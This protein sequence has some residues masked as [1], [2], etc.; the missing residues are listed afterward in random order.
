MAQTGGSSLV[1]G[2]LSMLAVKIVA[3]ALG[4]TQVALLS[5][6]QQLRQSAV[7]GATLTG[8]TA[9]V[10]GTSALSGSGRREFLRTSIVLMAIAT[11]VVSGVMMAFPEW[12]GR[13]AGLPTNRSGMSTYLIMAVIPA[14]AF[15]F[16]AAMMNAAGAIGSLALVQLAA[17]ATMAMMAYPI[18]SRV[19]R[20]S[21]QLWVVMLAFSS[22]A[23]AL[24]ASWALYID[25]ERLHGWIRGSGRWWDGS[26]V[27]RF[28]AISGSMFVSGMFSSWIVLAVRGQVVRSEGLAVGGQFDAAWA[29][30]MNQAG[31]VLASLQSYY[32]PTLAR[33]QDPEERSAHIGK[34]LT[35]AA[36]G[37]A[38]MIAVLAALKPTVITGLYSGQFTG[39]ARYLR[40]TLAGDYLKITS[41]ILSIPFVASGNMKAF[42][43]ADLAAYGMFALTAFGLTRWFDAGESAAMAFLTM[44]AVH[45]VFCGLWL[46]VR[47]EFRP[48]KRMIAVWTGGLGLV[49]ASSAAFWEQR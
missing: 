2:F 39:A 35:V 25:R 40:W 22:L 37:G 1:S 5:S 15:V 45:T 32:L 34:V 36:T 47:G 27:G 23:A 19:A 7:T 10:Q 48:D 30:S 33:T 18:A 17:P 46:S 29:I 6:L 43:T 20:G 4:P 31:L 14:V 41:W 8:Q 42:L 9:L 21:D 28:F 49:V 11:F 44:Y 38:A 16:L 3:V 13:Q 24:A 12:V 26:A